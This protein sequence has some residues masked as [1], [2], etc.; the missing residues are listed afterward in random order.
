MTHIFFHFSMASNTNLLNIYTSHTTKTTYVSHTPKSPF[1]SS[2]CATFLDFVHCDEIFETRM[3]SCPPA[4]GESGRPHLPPLHPNSIEIR[5]FELP[6]GSRSPLCRI[7]YTTYIRRAVDYC[8][9]K[10]S[11]SLWSFATTPDFGIILP[12]SCYRSTL[13]YTHNHA[14]LTRECIFVSP[15]TKICWIIVGGDRLKL[16]VRCTL[17]FHIENS[18]HYFFFA[19][20]LG[21]SIGLPYTDT[22]YD[23]S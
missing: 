6:R 21:I 19:I 13:L 15:L 18:P 20:D 7:L 9:Q 17:P 3:C 12:I 23:I 4:L 10:N 5:I 14:R 11:D 8:R 2:L 22:H 16:Q 1:V